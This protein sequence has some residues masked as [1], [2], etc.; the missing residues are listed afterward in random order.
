MNGPTWQT[1]EDLFF[2]FFEHFL[3]KSSLGTLCYRDPTQ[4]VIK[5]HPSNLGLAGGAPRPLPSVCQVVVRALPSRSQVAGKVLNA[6]DN[7]SVRRGGCASRRLDH[8]L[9]V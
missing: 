2:V 5:D 7:F 1:I 9:K 8:G 4:K 3:L 6:F